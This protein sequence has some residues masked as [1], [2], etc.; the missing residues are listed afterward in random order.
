MLVLVRRLIV[1]VPQV[2]TERSAQV[3]VD[4]ASPAVLHQPSLGKPKAR[5]CRR[6][7]SRFIP[8][9]RTRQRFRFR[10][11]SGEGQR[12]KLAHNTVRLGSRLSFTPIAPAVLRSPDLE[13]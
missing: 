8:K 6:H 13:L 9:L 11:R 2:R 7:I 12:G 1:R 4:L 5:S 10:D 3:A